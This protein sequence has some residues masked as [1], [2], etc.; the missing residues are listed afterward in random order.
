MILFTKA[1][2]VLLGRILSWLDLKSNPLTL[3]EGTIVSSSIERP[4]IGS[5]AGALEEKRGLTRDRMIRP[6]KK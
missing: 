6:E 5:T 2:S 3:F 1:L 4:I